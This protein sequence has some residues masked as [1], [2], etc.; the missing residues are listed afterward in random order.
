MSASLV[1]SEMCIRDRD[2]CARVLTRASTAN[3]FPRTGSKRYSAGF[4]RAER[5]CLLYTSD[6]ADDM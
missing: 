2:T 3:A 4:P 5:C 6:A 1:G